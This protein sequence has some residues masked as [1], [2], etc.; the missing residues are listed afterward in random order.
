MK[1]ICDLQLFLLDMDGTLYW[2]DKLIEGAKDFISF[3]DSG[4]IGYV[5]LTNNS[6]KGAQEYIKRM[7]DFGF[8]CTS[9]NVYT[10]GMATAEFLNKNYKGQ[11][12]YLMGTEALKREFED[13]NIILTEQDP[14]IVVVGFDMELSYSKIEKACSFLQSG[15]KFIATHPDTVC[16]ID[17]YRSIPDCGS[18]CAMITAATGRIP[19]FIGKPKRTM[20]DQMSIKWNVPNESIAMVGDRLYT[21]IAAGISAEATSICVLS[22]ETNEEDIAS[23]KWKPDYVFPSVKELLE[24]LKAGLGE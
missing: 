17:K 8:P 15:A 3:L 21:D 20:I 13:Y 7:R 19:E 18:M 2:G 11:R 10:S 5:F 4:G 23:S 9:R 24:E 12:V 16:P 22:G 14:E 1:K 6:S